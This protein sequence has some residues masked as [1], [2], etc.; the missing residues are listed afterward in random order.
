[1]KTKKMASRNQT[2]FSSLRLSSNE[3][4]SDF[5]SHSV[6]S[7]RDWLASHD[8]NLTK[9]YIKGE[10]YLV[11]YRCFRTGNDEYDLLFACVPPWYRNL[12]KIRRPLHGFNVHTLRDQ[13]NRDN[14]FM[15]VGVAY[16]VE[17]P[18]K[19]VPSFVWLERSKKRLNLIGEI[20][21]LRSA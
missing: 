17:C 15:M 8:L 6:Q 2:D 9:R 5:V 4:I 13:P 11:L 12:Q 3:D 1:M 21:G 16:S 20:F 14:H 18:E 10:L 7:S 19:I